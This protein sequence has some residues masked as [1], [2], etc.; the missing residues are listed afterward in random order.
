MPIHVSHTPLAATPEQAYDYLTI[1][2][3]WHEWHAASLGTRPDTP[4]PLIHGATFE[5][6]IRTAGFRRRLQWRVIASQRPHHWEALAAMDDGSR[7]RLRYDFAADG[8]GTR[9]TRTLDYDV[10]PLWLRAI[11]AVFGR[12]RIRRE[13]AAALSALQRRFVDG[14]GV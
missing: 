3:C 12:F 14:T 9:F 10:K 5:E 2:A 1:P 7:V 6:D 4:V 13:S 11:D 8:S